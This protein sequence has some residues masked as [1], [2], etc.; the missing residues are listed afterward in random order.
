MRLDDLKGDSCLWC[1]KEIDLSRPQAILRS[2]CSAECRM[3]YRNNL[4]HVALIEEKRGRR[5]QHC[6]APIPVTRRI[7]SDCCS[8]RCSQA[9]GRPVQAKRYPLTCKR[10]GSDFHGHFAGQQYCSLACSGAAYSARQKAK[11]GSIA[12]AHCS[13]VFDRPNSTQRFCS[14]ACA[15]AYRK[16]DAKEKLDRA[17]IDCGAEFKVSRSNTAGLRCPPCRHKHI[18]A[19]LRPGRHIQCE[20]VI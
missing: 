18:V 3:R 17:C 5:C 7:D 11:R 1:D 14:V 15:N 4:V 9:Y 10:C 13:T 12:C 2:Y 19:N 8:D 6:A 16:K 20:A